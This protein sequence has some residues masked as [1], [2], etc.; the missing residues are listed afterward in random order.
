MTTCDNRLIPAYQQIDSGE[1]SILSLDIF[2]TLLWRQVPEPRDLFLI[3]G[4]QLQK[5]GWLIPAVTAEN[6]AVLRVMAEKRSRQ[7]KVVF[8]SHAEVTLPEIYWE[9][10]SIFVKLSLEQMLS[11][12]S[13]GI[14]PQDISVVVAKEIVLEQEL[15]QCNP[16]IVELIVYAKQKGIPTVLVSDTYFEEAILWQWLARIS[17]TFSDS[18]HT[19]HDDLASQVGEAVLLEHCLHPLERQSQSA[20]R[21]SVQRKCEKSGLAHISHTFSD[22]SGFIYKMFLSSAYGISKQHGLFQRVIEELHVPS[23]RILHI[24]DNVKSDHKAARR[25]GMK[26]LYYPKISSAFKQI[27]NS[28]WSDDPGKRGILLDEKQGDFGL[29][30]LR[31]QIAFHTDVQ[32]LK[33]DD[34][35]FWRYGAQVL[36]PILF[37]F[38]YW[39]YERCHAMGQSSVF[40]LMREGKLYAELICRFARY[41]PHHTTL[42]AHPLWVS[43][44]FIV[45]ASIQKG[46]PKELM[47]LLKAFLKQVTVE[48]FWGYLGL[49]CDRMGKWEGS[50]HMMLEDPTLQRALFSDLWSERDFRQQ[51]IERSAQKRAS[52]L[53]YLGGLMDVTEP[54]Q[55][56]LVDVGWGGTI[57]GGIQKIFQL[58]DSPRILHGLYL[59]TT[60]A[61]Q[62]GFLEGVVRE[63]YLLRGSVLGGNFYKKGCFVLEQ[64]ATAPT[65]VGPLKDIDENG[66]IVTYPLCISL[67]QRQQAKMVQEGIFAFFDFIGPYIQSGTIQWDVHAEGLQNQLR[68]LLIRSMTLVTQQEALKF[69]SWFH[70]HAPTSHL[71]QKIGA[72]SYYDDFIQDMLPRNAF[73]E[74]ALNWLFAYTA[75]QSHPLTL[76]AQAVGLATLPPRC[77]LSEDHYHLNVFLDTEGNFPQKPHRQMILRSN[78]NRNFYTLLKLFFPRKP[79]QRLLLKLEFPPHSLVRIR[80]LRMLVFDRLS[81]EPEPLTFYEDPTQSMTCLVGK[82][83]DFNTFYCEGGDVQFMYAHFPPQVHQIQLNLCC[84]MFCVLRGGQDQVAKSK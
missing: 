80:S 46:S 70:D 58:I 54:G 59:A 6:F 9:L 25:A 50:R 8:K 7:K 33:G 79:L 45:H 67:Q 32:S 1:I 16:P 39:V 34:Q 20:E 64:I 2:D 17:H 49:D 76:T 52:F 82:P 40:C 69:G 84:E 24:G 27:L 68:T 83:I 26:T 77:F 57:Q 62:E 42:E 78:P 18:S 81:P 11:Q 10:E 37:G 74:N 65:G 14:Y 71:T 72:N 31:A 60:Q 4:K 44:Q 66:H 73:K 53:K 75:K 35:F 61:V 3:L 19:L 15:I 56:T 48:N 22:S 38:I 23:E 12:K 28:E 55:A 29:S 63:G 36:G 30:T 5:E 13:V 47:T 43:R 41:Y 21:R 51:I